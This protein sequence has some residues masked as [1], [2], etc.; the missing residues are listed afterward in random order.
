MRCFELQKEKLPYSAA[1]RCWLASVIADRAFHAALLVWALCSVA[2][3]VCVAKFGLSLPWCDEWLFTPIACGQQPLT[4]SW[5][6]EANNEHRMPLLRLGLFVIGRISHWDWQAMHY[7]TLA[8]M[9]LGALALLFAARSIRG[10]SALSDT[11]LCLVVLSPG[12]FETTW[13]YAYSFGAGGGLTCIALSL[14]AIRWPQRSLKHL[15]SY[16]LVVLVITLT[17]GPAGNLMALGLVGALA[18]CFWETGSRAWKIAA[19]VG[20]GLV[21][22]VSGLLLALI[23]PV[24]YHADFRSNSL[25]TTVQATLKESVCWLG[26]P[27]LHK[28]WPWASLIVLL[29]SLW[30]LGRIVRDLLRWRRG[31]QSR[32]REWIELFL[33][34]LATLLVA[35]SVAY[36][37]ARTELWLFRYMVL[38]M[39]IGLVLYLLL[40][41]M[42]APLAIL[43]ILAV[44]MAIF[45]GWNW[46]FML[47][48]EVPQRAEAAKL[49][50]KLAQGD[51]PLC[52]V[53]R[54][55][56]K[57]VG[58][59]LN[60]EWASLLTNL[61]TSWMMELR[62]NDQS[63]FRAINRGK[64]RA[65]GALPQAWKADSGK[66]GEGWL[67][68]PDGSATQ[69]R[70]L[71]VNA[72]GQ[73]AAFAVYHVQVAVGGAYQ[74]CCR[75]RAPKGQT[76]TVTVDGSQ[77][78]RQTFPAAAEFQLCVLAAPLELG[79]GQHELTL[80]LSPVCSDLDLLELVPRPPADPR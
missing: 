72:A 48:H 25:I 51:V 8:L 78:Q 21:T 18:L 61:L 15:I 66:R 24:P 46:R 41:R 20:S 7:A 28:L 59:S 14:A 60:P 69:A 3:C 54:Q 32:A 74:L 76:L 13:K 22:A 77:S 30:I 12:Q 39:P 36:G 50:R 23:P 65:G 58:L 71:R 10:H 33:V 49:L 56:C 67:S 64:R 27:V 42:R 45:F 75:M 57:D 53:C 6:W 38:T 73:Q 17:G 2:L 70:T 37:R 55:H 9:A 34:W 62:Q 52:V 19:G 35:A 44:G 1:L 79:P 11:F 40:V 26:P 68:Q 4:W 16:L 80:A 29:P 5:L 31:N 47:R 63:I 43:R